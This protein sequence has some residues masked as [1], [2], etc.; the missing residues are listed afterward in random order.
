M[1]LRVHSIFGDYFVRN[2]EDAEPSTTSEMREAA[3]YNALWRRYTDEVNQR[4]G[5]YPTRRGFEKW[6]QNQVNKEKDNGKR[7]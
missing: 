7:K 4:W 6:L 1:T 2:A 3:D 5:G